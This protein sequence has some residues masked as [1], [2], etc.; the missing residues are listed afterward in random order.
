MLHTVALTLLRGITQ[1]QTRDLLRHVPDAQRIF[2]QP[3]EA[4]AEA[5]PQMLR[6]LKAALEAHGSEALQRAEAEIAFCERHN[7]RVLSLNDADYPQRLADCP[8]APAV[9][10]FRGTADLNARRILSIVG[11][12]RIT[13]YGADLCRIFCT[14]LAQL[15]PDTLIVSG[16]AYGVDIHAHRHCVSQGLP[17]VG[18]L[19]H[20]LDQIYPATHRDTAKAMVGHGGLLT[21]YPSQTQAR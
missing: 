16:L 1:S 20:G 5:N 14:D 7:I 17:T 15:L 12:R 19:A 13:P 11:T 3:D 2:T 8:D 9:L 6:H 21:E 10:Y 4:L 18:V